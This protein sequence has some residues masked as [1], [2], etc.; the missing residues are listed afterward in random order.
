M[1]ALL[2]CPDRDSARRDGCWRGG[3]QEGIDAYVAS[4]RAVFKWAGSDMLFTWR[5]RP[6]PG[7]VYK[8]GLVRW[9][10]HSVKQLKLN[11]IISCH[12][13]YGRNRSSNSGGQRAA[14]H[15]QVHASPV[16]LTYPFRLLLS[17][18]TRRA[19]CAMKPPYICFN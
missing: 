19:K 16:S 13:K 5:S 8:H 14:A 9:I 4:L 7:H 1:R 15:T 17:C 18:F 10:A 2:L 12:A 11:K 3:V 6:Q